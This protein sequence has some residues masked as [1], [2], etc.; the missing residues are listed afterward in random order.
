MKGPP[1]KN[2]PFTVFEIALDSG[3]VAPKIAP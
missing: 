3:V 2:G 1:K